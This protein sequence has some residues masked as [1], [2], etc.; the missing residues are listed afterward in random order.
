MSAVMSSGTSISRVRHSARI[1]S[2]RRSGW[3]SCARMSVQ[4]QVSRASSS[5]RRNSRTFVIAR[6][7]ARWASMVRP[8]QAYW[9]NRAESTPTWVARKRTTSGAASCLERKKRPSYRKHLNKTANPKRVAPDLLPTAFNS[10]G[11]RVK[12]SSNSSDVHVRFIPFPSGVFASRLASSRQTL[13]SL[14]SCSL[15][16]PRYH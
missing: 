6:I 11:R 7:C 4:S 9:A 12:C 1:S 16:A 10:S 5:V 8:S 3:C 2:R 14:C 15:L 13:F